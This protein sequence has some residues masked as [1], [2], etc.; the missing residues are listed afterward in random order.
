MKLYRYNNLIVFLGLVGL[1]HG[2]L[3]Q[4][5][6]EQEEET[7]SV[8]LVWPDHGRLKKHRQELAIDDEINVIIGFKNDNGLQVISSLAKRIHNKFQRVNAVSAIVS[9]SVY[10]L[11]NE[12]VHI[13]YLEE[14]S[15]VYPYAEANLY[16]LN[17]VQ[18][19]S[20]AIPLNNVSFTAACSDPNS[21]KIGVSVIEIPSIR[22]VHKRQYI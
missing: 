13:L 9:R 14:D 22:Y 15:V 21:F 8:G 1:V 12:N 6:Q 10:N 2:R 5:L 4:H 7:D 11:L 3:N 19:E 16:G 17:M 20:S 18:A